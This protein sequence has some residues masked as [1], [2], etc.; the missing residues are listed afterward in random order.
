MAQPRAHLIPAARRVFLN[1]IGRV[2]VGVGLAAGST[3]ALGAEPA[4][5]RAAGSGDRVRLWRPLPPD[6]R[7]REPGPSRSRSNH[8]GRSAESVKAPAF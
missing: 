5:T 1:D 6:L 8:R 3:W 4:R 7:R 2:I